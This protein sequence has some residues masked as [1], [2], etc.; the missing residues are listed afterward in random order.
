ML[1]FWRWG[2]HSLIHL[3]TFLFMLPVN[4]TCIMISLILHIWEFYWN[5][6]SKQLLLHLN[7]VYNIQDTK[8]LQQTLA[9]FF[10]FFGSHWRLVLTLQICVIRFLEGIL[11]V[12]YEALLFSSAKLYYCWW[13]LCNGCNFSFLKWLVSYKCT[14]WVLNPQPHSLRSTCKGRKYQ[15]S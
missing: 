4:I 9:S 13:L 12:E 15:L 5:S 3:S 7:I 11:S 10:F 1:K 14:Q 8:R 6:Y 2:G